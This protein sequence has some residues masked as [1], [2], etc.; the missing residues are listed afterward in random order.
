MEEK[1]KHFEGKI[2]QNAV[3]TT[4]GGTRVLIVRDNDDEKWELPGGRLNVGE[5]PIDGLRRELQEELGIEVEVGPIYHT[6][7]IWHERDQRENFLIMYEVFVSSENVEFK[8]P[9]E[10]L[11]EVAW[12]DKDSYKQINMFKDTRESLDAY[13]ALK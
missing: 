12:V 10:E 4:K 1:E 8:V 7:T 6:Q 13:F 3:I 11:A 5:K 2:H 9:S